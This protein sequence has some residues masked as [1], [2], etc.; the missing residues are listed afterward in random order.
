M[1]EFIFNHR[2]VKAKGSPTVSL[3]DDI[4]K[5]KQQ[6]EK[7]I[8]LHTGDPDFDTPDIIKKAIV[9]ALNN[10][11]NHYSDSYGLPEL[12]QAVIEQIKLV[13]NVSYNISEILI[14]IGAIHAYYL[15]ISSLFN[16][17]DDLI[18][19]TPAWP[20]HLSYPPIVGVNLVQ[21]PCSYENKFLPDID[22]IKKAIT[23]NT[24]GIVLNFPNNPTGA[25]AS[26]T[27]VKQ[28]VELAI[29]FNLY[30]ISDEVYE[31]ILDSDVK[32]SYPSSFGEEAK[33]LTISINSFSKSHAVTGH[34]IGYLAAHTDIIRQ[35]V[36]LSQY[37][38][39]N[40]PTFIQKGLSEILGLHETSVACREMVLKYR[41]RNNIIANILSTSSR[42]IKFIKPAGG[43]YY[44]LKPVEIKISSIELSK[45]L[46]QQ[47]KV[48]MV[49]GAVYGSCGEN[50][51]RMTFAASDEEIVEGVH[52]FLDFYT[53]Y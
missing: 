42:E 9:R 34:R 26:E 11:Y 10:G 19:L 27:I 21:I 18:V 29:E 7:I 39:T 12:R 50:F 6:G 14:T 41:E 24:K 17:G 5:L 35:I 47:Q 48:A 22:D 49:P 32:L 1:G 16:F 45:C 23:K 53:K 38:V 46:L 33:R 4:R 15:A 31:T 2:I 52:R 28:I 30:I 36:K 8:P 43:F 44:F 51:L 3:A 25:V 20:T 37:S 13:K 40:A